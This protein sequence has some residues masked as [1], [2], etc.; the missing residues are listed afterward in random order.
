MDVVAGTRRIGDR[1]VL[2]ADGVPMKDREFPLIGSGVPTVAPLIIP[3]QIGEA[4]AGAGVIRS[5]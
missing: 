2:M 5:R 3:S 1:A 4:Q